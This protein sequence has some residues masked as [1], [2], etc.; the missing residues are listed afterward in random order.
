[1]KSSILETIKLDM[2]LLLLHMLLVSFITGYHSFGDNDHDDVQVT[3]TNRFEYR[4]EL[5]K[6][7]G[8]CTKL[9]KLNPSC[10]KNITIAY[11]EHP[12]YAFRHDGRVMGILPGKW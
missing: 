12:P 2:S 4:H 10:G 9:V 6:I 8:N 11:A 3:C 7:F 1:M 5:K